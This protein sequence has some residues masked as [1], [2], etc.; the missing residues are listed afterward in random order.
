MCCWWLLF[1]TKSYRVL[2]LKA[3]QHKVSAHST[4]KAGKVF[5]LLEVDNRLFVPTIPTIRM[6]SVHTYAT[7]QL[8]DTLQGWIDVKTVHQN[9]LLHIHIERNLLTD[10]SQGKPTKTKNKTVTEE[11]PVILSTVC[12]VPTFIHHACLYVY[13]LTKSPQKAG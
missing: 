6:V 4:G 13:M 7:S 5:R 9:S 8:F 10:Y 12:G 2:F 11:A 1:F 3:T